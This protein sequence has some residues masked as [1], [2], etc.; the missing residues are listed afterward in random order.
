MKSKKV[1][2]LYGGLSAER[3]V[4]LRSGT[5]AAK[6]L[7][8]AGFTDVTLIDAGHDLPARLLELKPDV[9]FNSLHGTF[10]EDGRIQGMLELMDIP[11]T[12]SGSQS[13]TIAFDKLLSKV[14]FALNNVPTPEY[15]QLTRESRAPFLP[16]V[17]KPCRQGSTIGITVAKTEEEF[18][19][20]KKEAFEYD[21][22]VIAERF[23]N[24]KELTIGILSSKVLP[25]IWIRPKSGFYDY[26][27]KYTKG[28]TAYVF[29]TELTEDEDKLIK[30]TALQ[31]FESLGCAS[32]GRV[33][34]MYD[35]KTPW[36]L[37]INTLPGLTETSLLPQAAAKTGISFPELVTAMISDALR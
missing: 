15:V 13:S 35:G 11:C 17:I 10:G 9:C 31:A 33:D 37:E 8:E 6:A 28:A 5:A 32:Y 30:S 36:V 18:V 29:E 21:E 25:I 34:I 23:I 4:S 2:V 22:R 24:G 12:G 3:E 14:I 26:Q 1:A 20:G 19:K 7:T 16:C 27:S